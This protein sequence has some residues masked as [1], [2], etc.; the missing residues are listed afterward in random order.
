[1]RG[2]FNVSREKNER[3]LLTTEKKKKSL[4]QSAQASKFMLALIYS[5]EKSFFFYFSCNES[6]KIPEFELHQKKNMEDAGGGELER[7][8][9]YRRVGINFSHPIH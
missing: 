8:E 9:G 6:R 2:M 1:V 5:R 3:I 7:G 4:L